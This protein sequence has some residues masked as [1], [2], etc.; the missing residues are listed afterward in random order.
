[1]V[2][3]YSWRFAG[4][5][6]LSMLPILAGTGWFT[7]V[8]IAG[9]ALVVYGI[10]QKERSEDKWV[11]EDASQVIIAILALLLFSLALLIGM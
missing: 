10:I 7:L 11:Y 5:A 6:I 4:L 3:G 1:M 8:I 9:V 2:R